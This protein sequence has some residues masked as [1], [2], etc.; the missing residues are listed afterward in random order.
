MGIKSNESLSQWGSIN[1]EIETDKK[2]EDFL[3]TLSPKDIKR[4]LKGLKK[5]NKNKGGK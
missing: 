4:F 2:I 3:D 1:E 5:R